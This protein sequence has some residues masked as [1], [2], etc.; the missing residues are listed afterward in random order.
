MMIIIEKG[1]FSDRLI[2]KPDFSVQHLLGLR[3]GTFIN[4]HIPQST[5]NK[6][7]WKHKKTH[8]LKLTISKAT[9]PV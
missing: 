5:L 6:M 8:I 2:F 9:Q 3:S 7:L 4:Y 1:Y